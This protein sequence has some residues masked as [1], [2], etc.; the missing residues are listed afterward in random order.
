MT[1]FNSISEDSK[2]NKT[3]RNS[4]LNQNRETSNKLDMNSNMYRFNVFLNGTY[5]A[6]GKA[7]LFSSDSTGQQELRN[8]KAQC[9]TTFGLVQC[10]RIFTLRGGEIADTAHLFFDD[11]L[12]ITSSV[13]EQFILP[14]QQPQKPLGPQKE[15]IVRWFTTDTHQL[16]QV[17]KTITA[18]TTT[19]Q[20][21]QQ[22]LEEHISKDKELDN[23]RWSLIHK[24]REVPDMQLFEYAKLHDQ[25]P[26]LTFFMIYKP[27]TVGFITPSSR[28]LVV[29][30]HPQEAKTT[31][32]GQLKE[33]LSKQE[34]EFMGNMAPKLYQK[35]SNQELN[36]SVSI[37]QLTQND[38]TDG[39]GENVT[40]HLK[41]HFSFT[42]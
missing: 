34:A 14:M 42:N 29:S 38:N 7:I 33:L 25:E 41:L 28:K 1:I 22:V 19:S 32:V 15:V 39:K 12:I 13:D 17:T 27:F 30:L 37:T 11:V 6:N 18:S 20:L 21:K 23:F 35:G 31:T 8:L 9:A 26:V 10:A 4:S 5:P 2:S 36:D 16:E 40:I 24:G 3:K